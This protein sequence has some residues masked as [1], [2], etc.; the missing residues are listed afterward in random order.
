MK[1]A[2]PDL[3]SDWDDPHDKES[4]WAWG[5]AQNACVRMGMD[6]SL[7]MSPAH[8]VAI[9]AYLSARGYSVAKTREVWKVVS[10][11]HNFG[12]HADP[13]E[14]PAARRAFVAVASARAIRKMHTGAP[15]RRST[16]GGTK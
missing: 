8:V 16:Q 6:P 15:A 13:C 10:I 4:H 7:P 12:G 1:R 14:A 9:L 11:V 3:W 5:L 2:V